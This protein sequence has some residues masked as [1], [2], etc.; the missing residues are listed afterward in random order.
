M[1]AGSKAEVIGDTF[2]LSILVIPKGDPLIQGQ[3]RDLHETTLPGR[4]PITTETSSCREVFLRYL[5]LATYVLSMP[6]Y[7]YLDLCYKRLQI[8]SS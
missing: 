8:R 3:R 5:Y 2:L 7:K 4:P 1:I 6:S